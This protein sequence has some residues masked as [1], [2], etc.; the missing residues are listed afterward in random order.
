MRNL[1]Y[2]AC[3]CSAGLCMRPKLGFGVPRTRALRGVRS[4]IGLHSRQPLQGW[5]GNDGSALFG[6]EFNHQVNL[7]S[8]A[9]D[10]I[11][12]QP[13]AVGVAQ[14]RFAIVFFQL[15]GQED[16]LL[17]RHGRGG[18]KTVVGE[19][20]NGHAAVDLDRFFLAFC[21]EHQPPAEST[22][23]PLARLLH[24]AVGPHCHHA[25]G[26]MRFVAFGPGHIQVQPFRPVHRGATRER[27]Q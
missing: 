23:A 12:R 16:I 5:L 17:F 13:Y 9:A 8:G 11:P 20:V 15:F 27:Q 3:A 18:I 26:Y 24:N 10:L 1:P 25:R 14:V 22:N 19:G 21:I 7:A 2:A 6:F 4:L